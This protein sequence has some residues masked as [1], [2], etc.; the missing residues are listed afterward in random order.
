MY[1][2]I[3]DLALSDKKWANALAKI[4]GKLTDFGL[5]GRVC[6]LS[7]LKSVRDTVLEELRHSPKTVVVVGGDQLL[8]QVAGLLATSGVALGII[9]IGDKLELAS[10][11]GITEDNAVSVLSARRLIGVDLGL[12]D[13]RSFL[14][15]LI[16]SGKSMKL[17]VDGNYWLKF[18]DD[19][20]V[21]VANYILEKD[22][23]PLSD[24]PNPQSGQLTVLL[25]K[26]DGGFM[27]KKKASE[28]TAIKCRSLD[29]V[30]ESIS[31]IIDGVLEMDKA[32]HIT[33]KN[34]VLDIIVGRQRDF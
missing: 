20:E 8:T 31:V 2:Y 24:R 4:E 10:S 25:S 21:E 28:Q 5:S 11:L 32:E 33:V 23:C 16:L 1:T 14:K 29:V 18:S 7:Q 22:E 26:K 17:L 12:V 34:R 27:S 19:D 30:A 13:N 9:P 6:R 3:Y 15:N